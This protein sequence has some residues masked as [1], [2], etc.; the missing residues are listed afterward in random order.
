[1]NDLTKKIIGEQN[2]YI[3]A[4]LQDRTTI[5][6]S[7]KSLWKKL[8]KTVEELYGLSKIQADELNNIGRTDDRIE[9][10]RGG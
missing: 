9:I 8:D 4:S 1:L 3:K 10:L 2:K 6:G 5:S 7:L